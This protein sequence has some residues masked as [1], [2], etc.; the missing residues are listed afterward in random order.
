MGDKNN[1]IEV[2]SGDTLVKT[3]HA[4]IKAIY[5]QPGDRTWVIRDGTSAAG[6]LVMTVVNDANNHFEAPYINHPVKNG[7]FVDNTVAGTGGT[8][9]VVYE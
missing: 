1:I 6:T 3:G 8:I 5:A 2:G 4:I 7:I 9:V